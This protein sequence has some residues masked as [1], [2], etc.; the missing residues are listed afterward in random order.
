MVHFCFFSE[1]I[2]E[3][4]YFSAT[5]AR[6]NFPS[7]FSPAKRYLFLGMTLNYLQSL[8]NPGA[9]HLHFYTLTTVIL[10]Y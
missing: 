5:F 7:K 1:P 9:G 6:G 10:P 8:L 3:F 4:K 2:A